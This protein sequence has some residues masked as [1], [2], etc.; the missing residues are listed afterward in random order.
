MT[1][2]IALMKE[3]QNNP[4]LQANLEGALLD[5][6]GEI[7]VRQIV[8]NQTTISTKSDESPFTFEF[9]PF[10]PVFIILDPVSDNTEVEYRMGLTNLLLLG[11]EWIERGENRLLNKLTLSLDGQ[12][13]SL[14]LLKPHSEISEELRQ[15][16]STKVT[17][18]LL[19]TAA[20]GKAEMVEEL[21]STICILL[22]FATGT[23]VTWLWEDCFYQGK[24]V[25]TT[26]FPSKTIPYH[27][28][29]SA[30]DCEN[31]KELQD[32]VQTSYPN[33]LT[34]KDN[35]GLNIVI[36]YYIHSKVARLLEL[37]YLIASIGMECLKS[38][39]PQYIS[40]KGKKADVS[41]F[42]KSLEVLFDE[43]SMPYQPSEL[44]FIG[45]R[46]KIIHT[47]RFPPGTNIIDEYRSLINLY[48]R[49]IL[50]ILAYRGKPYL[51]CTK[52]YARELIP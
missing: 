10:E 8:L 18:H 42:R 26:L 48:D 16:R 15:S 40:T 43:H 7:K 6:R 19:T 52:K 31:G 23:W 21:A 41:T 34:A 14:E 51:N 5:M 33:Y 1:K 32:F 4:P 2:A 49:A 24:L 36:E 29:D 35:L 3:D 27:G 30:I 28:S 46:D 12:T 38:H 22:S 9:L 20:L 37:K 17:S 25:R 39:V 45:I 50:T 47:G 13:L 44:D 11:T